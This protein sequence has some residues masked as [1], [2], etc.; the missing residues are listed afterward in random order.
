MGSW[1]Y[2]SWPSEPPSRDDAYYEW[3]DEERTMSNDDLDQREEQGQYDEVVAEDE[4][5]D[6]G[7]WLG[8]GE[9]PV[10]NTG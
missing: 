6:W 2:F 10:A 1:G 5:N 3:L 8:Q 4:G 9:R 7:A